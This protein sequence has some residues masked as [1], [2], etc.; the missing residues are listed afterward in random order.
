MITKLDTISDVKSFA[1]QI[2]SDGV[3]FHPD[4]DFNDYVNFK[5]KTPCYTKE[6]AEF[7]NSLMDKCFEVCEKEGVDIYAVMLEVSLTETGLDKYIPLPSQ[8]YPENN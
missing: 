7:R 8:P 3:S 1:K 2:I 4:D 5:E 6:E